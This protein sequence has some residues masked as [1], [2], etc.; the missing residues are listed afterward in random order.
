[1]SGTRQTRGT[2]VQGTDLRRTKMY[3]NGSWVDASSGET[4]A[5]DESQSTRTRL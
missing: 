3:I 4:F 1:M 2:D 5:S